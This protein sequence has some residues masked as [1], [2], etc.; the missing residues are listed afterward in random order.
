MRSTCATRSYVLLGHSAVPARG[1]LSHTALGVRMPGVEP[2]SQAW[3]G[4]HDT[5]TLHKRLQAL[6]QRIRGGKT[7]LEDGS[8]G[9]ATLKLKSKLKPQTLHP[10]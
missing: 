5:T 4:L 9:I 10:I 2:G 6:K 1:Q 3:G 7:L 8:L